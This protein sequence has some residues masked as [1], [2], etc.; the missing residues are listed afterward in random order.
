[1]KLF[2]FRKA[3]RTQPV[4]GE[5]LIIDD[6]PENLRLLN[7]ILSDHGY[8]VRALPN[9][10]MGISACKASPPDLVLLDITMPGMNGYEVAEKLKA[11][12]STS[13]VPII[14]IS[15]MTQTEDKVRAFHAGGVDYVTKPLQV[16][17][18]LARV[19][20]H[21]S[22]KRMREQIEHA[23]QKLLVWNVKLSQARSSRKSNPVLAVPER[24]ANLF[25]KAPSELHEG[26]RAEALLSILAVTSSSTD[27]LDAVENGL[28]TLHDGQVIARFSNVLVG[29][30]PDP[31][32][33][34]AQWIETSCESP[35]FSVSLGEGKGVLQVCA[36]G[37]DGSGSRVNFQCAEV[38]KTV[39][40]L[41]DSES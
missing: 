23:N 2:R 26:D 6:T 3:A 13:E 39:S 18:V 1:M 36:S 27:S 11:G 15:A 8:K 41:A 21:L 22:I 14:F 10:P 12:A 5:I 4:A 25:G 40:A 24:M 38:L 33:S 31:I 30:S 17:E 7:Q 35:D 19:E 34:I 32:D 9:G 20:T 28:V 37:L 29:I 16:E